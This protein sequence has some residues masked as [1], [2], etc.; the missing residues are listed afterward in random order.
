VHPDRFRQEKP[1]VKANQAI[2]VKAI[3]DRFQES[4]FIAWQQNSSL[5]RIHG[6]AHSKHYPYVVERRDGSFLNASLNLN[7]PVEEILASIT[8]TL[9][10]AGVTSLPILPKEPAHLHSKAT[11]GATGAHPQ[12]QQYPSGIDHRYDVISRRGRDFW[13]FLKELDTLE[14]EKRQL[15]RTDAQSAALEV[16]RTFQ[17]QSVDATSLGWSSESVAMLLR[18]LL[19]LHDEHDF[20]VRS[21]Y[22]IRCMFQ[23]DERTSYTPASLD[24]SSGILLLN[25]AATPVQWLE[26]LRQVTPEAIDTIKESGRRLVEWTKLAQ[27]ALGVKLR[28]GHS[29]T[30][31]EY[32]AF[33]RQICSDL[34]ETESVVIAAENRSPDSLILEPLVATVE[35]DEACRR[36]IVTTDGS[37]RVGAGMSTKRVQQFI[38]KLS[39]DARARLVDHRREMEHCKK[40]IGQMQWDLGVQNVYATR[41]VNTTVFCASLTRILTCEEAEQKRQLK[42]GLTGHSLGIASSGHFCHLSDDGSVVIPHDWI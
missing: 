42:A 14:I 3:S 32:H 37:I 11:A 28:K 22:P 10:Q 7:Q 30:S 17:F 31:R 21:F 13:Y 20:H 6:L 41:N 9:K 27:R 18:Q 4:D 23:S 16:R 24:L 26:N 15:F 2:L 5:P 25:P 33:L 34:A 12:T 39:A 8:A 38:A 35:A 19:L 1:S 29:C 36:A 40:A